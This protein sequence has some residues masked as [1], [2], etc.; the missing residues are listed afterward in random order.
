MDFTD[1]QEHKMNTTLIAERVLDHTEMLIE[2]LKHNYVEYCIRGHKRSANL[3]DRVEEKAYH[4][5]KV[6][7]VK[8]H[9]PID[10]LIDTGRNFTFQDTFLL[11]EIEACGFA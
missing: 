1:F 3:A 10:F 2:A 8:N 4:M 9:C 11:I 5:S 7:E 6:E